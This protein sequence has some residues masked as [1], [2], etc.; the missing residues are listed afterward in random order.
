MHKSMLSF[1]LP[2]TISL[3]S[4]QK[5][6][7]IIK[8]ISQNTQILFFDI[9][10]EKREGENI[11][12]EKGKNLVVYPKHCAIENYINFYST[13]FENILR[14]IP[15][16]TLKDKTGTSNAIILN[17]MVTTISIEQKKN[18]P[19]QFILKEVNYDKSSTEC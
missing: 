12:I 17:K 7:K 8:L 5:H 1:L 18:N 19:H 11:E 16:T 13:D 4:M 2:F 9:E 10:I 14:L 3:Y 6:E 15:I